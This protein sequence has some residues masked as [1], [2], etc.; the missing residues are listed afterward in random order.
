MVEYKP[1]IIVGKDQIA[2]SLVYFDRGDL[3]R[4]ISGQLG[5][6]IYNIRWDRFIDKVGDKA[7]IKSLSNQNL[8]VLNADGHGELICRRQNIIE[9]LSTNHYQ[10]PT[11]DGR[12][13]EFLR[14][15]VKKQIN[16]LFIA[17]SVEPVFIR[18]LRPFNLNYEY[19]RL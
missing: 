16:T 8:G 19:I 18:Y 10:N 3:G 14:N 9:A 15:I 11:L 7:G 17:E 12:V 1:I 13:L 4:L 5:D 6:R 2:H